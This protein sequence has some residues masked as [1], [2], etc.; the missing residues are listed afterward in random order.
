MVGHPTQ[1]DLSVLREEARKLGIV[2]LTSGCDLD[3]KG[4]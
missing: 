3:G 2:G 4:N 1:A